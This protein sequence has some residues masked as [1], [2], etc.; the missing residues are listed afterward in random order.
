MVA[1]APDFAVPASLP[2]GPV[3]VGRVAED[4]GEGLV[5]TARGVL[6][7][8]TFV[9]RLRS[10][11]RDHR[12]I[13]S[14]HRLA[15]PRVGT[16]RREQLRRVALSGLAVE[17]DTGTRRIDVAARAAAVTLTGTFTP[18]VGGGALRLAVTRRCGGGPRGR[19]AVAGAPR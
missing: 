4:G 17:I 9:P 11:L 7:R 5:G 8:R 10:A 13:G 12:S 15:P 1:V 2:E 14:S 16:G 19:G 3:V 6:R 18:T